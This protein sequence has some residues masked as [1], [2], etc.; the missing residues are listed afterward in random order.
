MRIARNLALF[1]VLCA[2]LWLTSA[3]SY[4]LFHSLVEM[5]SIAIAAAVFMISWSSRG[6]VETQ[7][8]VILGIGY[9]FVSIL[10]LL[11]TL[12]Y[13]GMGV[14]PAGQDYATKLWV[15]ARGLQAAVTLVFVLLARAGRTTRSL[16][17]FLVVGAAA[18]L[19]VLSIFPWNIFPLSFVEGQGV[20]LFKKLSEYAISAVLVLC[21][22]LIA[23]RRGAI[24]RQERWLLAAA[25]ALNAISEMVFTLYVSAYGYQNLIGHLLKLGSFLLAYQ[26]LFSTKIRSRLALIEELRKSTASLE[27]SEAE[28]RD[29]EPFQGQVLL[30]P[31]PRPSKSHQRHRLSLR[32]SHVEV[33]QA[34]AGAHPRDVRVHQRG[35]AADAELLEC[36]LQWARAQTGRLEVKPSAVPLAE[37]CDGIVSLQKAAAERKGRDDRVPRARRCHGVGR[38]EHDGN[39]A[40]QPRLECRQV[41]PARRPGERSAPRRRAR[42]SG[43]R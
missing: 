1:L 25:F 14:L 36:I 4:L 24:S 31:R 40:A 35:G 20:T 37:L 28:L 21:I 23:G 29:R 30:H 39:R 13:Q 19:A 8:F 41:H 42:G 43:S 32:A 16:P 10:D 33:R 17:A 22:T 26:A 3:Y 5:M 12:S 27:E 15:A 38:R 6:Y 7:P 2:A 11:H 34:G 18:A 9:L